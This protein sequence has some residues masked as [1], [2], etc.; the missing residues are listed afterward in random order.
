MVAVAQEL[1]Y[2]VVAEGVETAGEEVF[3]KEVGVDYVQ[4]FLYGR[5]DD[6]RAFRTWMAGEAESSG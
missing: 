1:H 2:S 4:G 5:A 6:G 3:I